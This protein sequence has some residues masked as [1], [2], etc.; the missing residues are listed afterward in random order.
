MTFIDDNYL[1]GI[2]TQMTAE[3]KE[4]IMRTAKRLNLP[5]DDVLFLYIGAVEYTVQLC[6]DI[7]SGISSE[8]Q[9]IEQSNQANHQAQ[10]EQSTTQIKNLIQAGRDI[11]ADIQKTGSATTS[12]IASANSETLF[13]AQQTMTAA[14]ELT[15]STVAL[16]GKVEA[17]RLAHK[18]DKEKLLEQIKS[19]KVE[20][21]KAIDRTIG[22]Y[23]AMDKLQNKIRLSTALGS[24][25]PLSALGCAA[26]GGAIV[27]G[28]GLHMYWGDAG[29]YLTVV[30]ENRT[31]LTRCFTES[32]ERKP[33]FT[34]KVVPQKKK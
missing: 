21:N 24:I 31:A 14:A 5:D 2:I 25:A 6:E 34:C 10:Q 4:N 9:L 3:H 22:M 27:Y 26:I 15:T 11:V 32:G 8:R 20:L 30:K 13:Q 19:A 17:D 7:L 28:W 16:I 33:G 29:N 12:A 1:D 23:G 18:Q